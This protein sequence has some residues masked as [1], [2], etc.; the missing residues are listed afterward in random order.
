MSK[1]IKRWLGSVNENCNRCHCHTKGSPKGDVANYIL[2]FINALAS[3]DQDSIYY[4]FLKEE[5]LIHCV[6]KT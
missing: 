1:F 3:L 2:N 6:P 4:V 5:D